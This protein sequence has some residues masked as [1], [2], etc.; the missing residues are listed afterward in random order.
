MTYREEKQ[1]NRHTSC[2]M[3]TNSEK[4]Q[5]SWFISVSRKRV[6]RDALSSNV[7]ASRLWNTWDGHGSE[8]THTIFYREHVKPT[9]SQSHT[10]TH[11]HTHT[12][13]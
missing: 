12:H 7:L 6:D 9:V 5:L 4:D 3:P 8:N 13:F 1:F 11:T 2:I 10:H